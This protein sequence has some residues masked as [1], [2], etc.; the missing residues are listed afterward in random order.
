MVVC[1]A[2]S[3]LH[4][5][6]AL[7]RLDPVNLSKLLMCSGL[8]G[9]RTLHIL[10]ACRDRFQKMEEPFQPTL[11]LRLPGAENLGIPGRFTQPALFRLQFAH[12]AAKPGVFLHQRTHAFFDLGEP[13]TQFLHRSSACRPVRGSAPLPSCTTVF[14]PA[15]P[16]SYS[17]GP[18]EA[19][20]TTVRSCC[21][22]A[23][24]QHSS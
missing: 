6:C 21:R 19:A 15:L 8:S 14:P 16:L 12:L 20:E 10:F 11:H 3:V 4:D 7:I 22:Y 9:L 23:C 24:I 13:R 2:V 18:E 1:I 17:P 5:S